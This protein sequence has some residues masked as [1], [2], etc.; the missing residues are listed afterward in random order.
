ML[1]MDLKG[2]KI[3]NENIN[4]PIKVKGDKETSTGIRYKYGK[5]LNLDSKSGLKI[6]KTNDFMLPKHGINS[7]YIIAKGKNY[8][9]YPNDYNKY[10]KKYENSFQH[11]GISLEEMVIPIVSLTGKER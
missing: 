7:E 1:K 5:N 4:K 6:I 11:G 3:F 10:S 2:Q 8:F 9:I